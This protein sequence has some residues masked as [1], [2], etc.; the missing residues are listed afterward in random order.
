MRNDCIKSFSFYEQNQSF[1][2]FLLKIISQK[3]KRQ[4]KHRQKYATK[5][6]SMEQERAP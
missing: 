4:L 3:W 6:H 1:L 5:Q 2:D